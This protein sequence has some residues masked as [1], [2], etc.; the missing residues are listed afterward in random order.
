[1]IPHFALYQDCSQPTIFQGSQT[2]IK[3]LGPQ[4]QRR[5]CATYFQYL[6]S[7]RY[8][9]LIERKLKLLSSDFFHYIIDGI[10]VVSYFIITGNIEFISFLGV[11]CD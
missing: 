6:R 3:F 1:M 2:R 8:E 11:F 10:V 9:R 4:K 5:I 7:Y